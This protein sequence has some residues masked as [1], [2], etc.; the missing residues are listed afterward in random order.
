MLLPEMYLTAT[1]CRLL[2]QRRNRVPWF[3]VTGAE[4]LKFPV[5]IIAQNK[6]AQIKVCPSDSVYVFLCRL[7]CLACVIRQGNMFSANVCK[8]KA[9]SEPDK[10][11]LCRIPTVTCLRTNDLCQN[12]VWFICA[13]CRFVAGIRDEADNPD[14]NIS[15]YEACV[16]VFDESLL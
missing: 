7:M 13:S 3:N 14:V 12:H 2:Q 11:G 1:D 5:I 16:G 8:H 9:V 6:R 4:L 10:S 15:N